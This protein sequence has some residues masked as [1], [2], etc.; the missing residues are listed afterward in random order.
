[1]HHERQLALID[2]YLGFRN[3]A[4]QDLAETSMRNPAAAYVDAARFDREMKVLFRERPVPIGLSC[5]C[6]E[7][8]SYL[9]A[10]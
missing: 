7:P 5:E 10:R 6:K 1:M 2:R 4:P 9:T 3:G 8:G